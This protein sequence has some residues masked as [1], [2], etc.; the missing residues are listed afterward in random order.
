LKRRR[1]RAKL[2][3]LGALLVIAACAQYEASSIVAFQPPAER[4]SLS[5]GFGVAAEAYSDGE[6]QKR[7]FDADMRGTGVIPIRV[8]V[9]NKNPQPISVRRSEIIL[10][11]ADGRQ[12]S[13]L[14]SEMV[15]AQV[16]EGGSP[17]AASMGF[18][19]LG[20]LVAA[21]AQSTS[22]S[23]RIADYRRKEFKDAQLG[24]D[25]SAQGFVFFKPAPG[26]K[27]FDDA[28]LTV[29]FFDADSGSSRVV[30]LH[31]AGLRFQGNK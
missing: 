4:I 27:P 24:K 22:R 14:T 30:S 25:Q 17:V 7:T 18:G 10:K 19:L 13:T 21:D 3:S 31:L 1:L 26:T 16:G 2:P 23:Q 20:S 9:V 11:L 28:E 15:V 8:Y 29:R 12:I 6:N 5:D